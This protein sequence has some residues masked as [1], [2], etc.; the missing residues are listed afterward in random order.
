MTFADIP[1][2]LLLPIAIPAAVVFVVASFGVWVALHPREKPFEEAT[3][4]ADV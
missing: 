4:P 3:L 1:G 2:T